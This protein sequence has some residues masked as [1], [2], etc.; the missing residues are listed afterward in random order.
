LKVVDRAARAGD[1]LRNDRVLDQLM[2]E[3]VS[4][5]KPIGKYSFG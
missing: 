3:Q 5:P 2:L 1:Q 4:S